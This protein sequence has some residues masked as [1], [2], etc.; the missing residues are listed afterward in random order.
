MQA[1][2]AAPAGAVPLAPGAARTR[3]ARLAATGRAALEAAER[4]FAVAALLLL[5]GG[6]LTLLRNPGRYAT[7]LAGGDPVQQAGG[8]QVVHIEGLAGDF[9]AAFFARN[10]V[11]YQR[12]G[13]GPDPTAIY[14]RAS[15]RRAVMRACSSAAT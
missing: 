1:T 4:G 11:T 10:G 7:D 2:V 6:G 3:P 8:R 5:T 14:V 12:S 9:R 15:N 13:H